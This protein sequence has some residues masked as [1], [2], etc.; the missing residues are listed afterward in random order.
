[1][2]SDAEVYCSALIMTKWEAA[3]SD[4]EAL[5]LCARND[6]RGRYSRIVSLLHGKS[7]KWQSPSFLWKEV[8]RRGGGW[9]LQR[10]EV[11]WGEHCLVSSS[12]A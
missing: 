6:D 7:V 3:L 8:P 1:M 9:L 2:L 12:R 11:V 5:L 4:A 10:G